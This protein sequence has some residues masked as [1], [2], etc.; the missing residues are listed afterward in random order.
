MT[1]IKITMEEKETGLTRTK[2][3]RAEKA[4]DAIAVTKE[5]IPSG[6]GSPAGEGSQHFTADEL[7]LISEALRSFHEKTREA[8]VTLYG[9][10][11]PQSLEQ[12][13]EIE[14]LDRKVCGYIPD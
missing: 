1:H 9:H 3:V 6:H 14:D 8:A 12:C 4:E 7:E 10:E 11:T 2:N 13:I 5:L